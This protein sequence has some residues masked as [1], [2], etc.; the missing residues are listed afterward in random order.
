MRRHI[1]GREATYM[2]IDSDKRRPVKIEPA[3]GAISDPTIITGSA[4]SQI[5]TT[6]KA[7]PR[8]RKPQAN[9]DRCVA[10]TPDLE[11]HRAELRQAFGNTLSDEFAEFMLG[12]LVSALRPSPFDSLD[13]T[14][15]NAAI[16]VVSSINPQTEFEALIAVQMAA[17]GFAGLKF[18]RQSQHNMDE[19]YIGVYGGYAAKLF[20]LQL[21]MMQ[22]LDR[23]RR[24]NTQSVEVRHLHIHSGAQ[25]VVGIVNA[26]GEKPEGGLRNDTRPR[27][28]GG[29][30]ATTVEYGQSPPM[31]GKDPRWSP[32]PT[33]GGKG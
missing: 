13:E 28:S 20:R 6:R 33:G 21:D 23:H 31:W 15:L 29:R 25:G 9:N 2:A 32:L 8:V 19:I 27:A 22:A 30:C 17:S 18:L 1:S 24:G 3:D 11:A 12:K 16:A 26:A 10:P 5:S 14:T 7:P 4:I